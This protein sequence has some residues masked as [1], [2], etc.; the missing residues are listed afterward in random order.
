MLA[1][2]G[3]TATREL[4]PFCKMSPDQRTAKIREMWQADKAKPGSIC[5]SEADLRLSMLRVTGC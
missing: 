2:C 4:S 3:P 5:A 1:G